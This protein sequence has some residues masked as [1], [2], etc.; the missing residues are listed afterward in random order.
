MKN[1]MG[2]DDKYKRVVYENTKDESEPL[3]IKSI[4]PI[5]SSEEI[6][7]IMP[8]K[9]IKEVESIMPIK[10]IQEIK[11]MKE[12]KSIQPVPNDIARKFIKK[13]GLTSSIGR[14]AAPYVNQV[15][16]VDMGE[17]EN[18]ND[19]EFSYS[20][21]SYIKLL[22]K[23]LSKHELQLW[24]INSLTEKVEEAIRNSDKKINSGQESEILD[25]IKINYESKI[26]DEIKMNYAYAQE[27]EIPDY[28][29]TKEELKIMDPIK[30]ILP[31]K[32]ITPIKSVK[33]IKS[34]REVKGLYELTKK[35]ADMLRRL[36]A[37]K[38]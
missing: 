18:I 35:Q 22:K 7:S 26:P 5:K 14:K 10:S 1:E 6:K 21:L 11:S 16:G 36:N 23:A 15:N 33:P 2:D 4:L 9:S 24:I 30:S 19:E 3:K 37:I 28:I 20:S 13:H 8:I 27:S 31:I 29:K 38:P 34:I 12:V 17:S 32:E 25:E